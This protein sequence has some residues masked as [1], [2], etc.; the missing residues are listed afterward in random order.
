MASVQI[1]D[2]QIEDA[3][4]LLSQ[5]RLVAFPTETV[6]GLGADAS[7]AYA[8][9][10]LYAV[11]GRPTDHPVIVHLADVADLSKW[12]IN[13]PEAAYALADVF[14]PGPLTIILS[15]ADH[16]L[17]LVT[18]GQPSIGLRIPSHPLAKRLIQA[19][20][21][22]VAAPSANRF[23]KLSP[24]TA[25][26]VRE[27]LGKDVDLILD[28]GP[29]QVGIESTIVSLVGDKPAILRPGMIDQNKIE[30]V[31]GVSLDTGERQ[32]HDG[33]LG[34]TIRV[35]GAL[36]SHYAP[37]TPMAVAKTEDLIELFAEGMTI[38]RSQGVIAFASTVESMKTNFGEGF[39]SALPY[40]AFIVAPQNADEYAQMLY[41][42]LRKLDRL[43]LH[44][45]LVEAVPAGSVWDGVRDRLARASAEA[46]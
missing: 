23:G 44:K 29:C 33:Q 8:L 30:A 2:Q 26:A 37:H 9:K 17:P 4:K 20:G 11:K 21:G 39:Y 7:S 35:P 15:K 5:G 12:A 10:R 41:D 43:T 14:W 13:I 28:G 25:E 16:V 27:C 45:I 18:G 24:T 3:A 42:G 31:L 38:G 32:K 19:F 36:P 46:R 40:E 22:G 6:Y 34:Q 1:S